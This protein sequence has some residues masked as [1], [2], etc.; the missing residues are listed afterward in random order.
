VDGTPAL[1][2]NGRYLNG[3]RPYEEIAAIVDEELKTKR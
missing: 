3:V 2:V 1:F